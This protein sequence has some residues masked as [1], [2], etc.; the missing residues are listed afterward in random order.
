MLFVIQNE[1]IKFQKNME[2]CLSLF[3]LGKEV[4]GVT[5]QGMKYNLDNYTMTN[6]FPIGISNEFIGEEG[7]IT[8]RDGEVVGMITYFID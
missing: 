1:T 3:S 5:I 7:V 2:G 4:K 6:D 8:V